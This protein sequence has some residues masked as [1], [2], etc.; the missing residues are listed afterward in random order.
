MFETIRILV[1]QYMVWLIFIPF[2][3]AAVNNKN[4][5]AEL[6]SVFYYL[7]IAV[8]TQIISYV[9]WLN[10]KPNL[11][12]LHVYTILEFLILLRFYSIILRGFVPRL[13]FTILLILFPLFAFTD[14]IFL[15]NIFTV[16]TYSRSVEALIFI[17]LSVSWFVKMVSED[18]NFHSST[19]GISYINFGFFIYFSGS[20]VL[21][22]FQSYVA[23]FSKFLYLN[24]WTIHSLLL[25]ILYLLITIGLWKFKTK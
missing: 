13:L 3:I 20:L 2:I 12:L 7:I 21:F 19:P 4:Y 24:I 14:S 25:I 5:P 1:F 9:Y 10:S 11:Y 15:E 16:N 18:E 6:K 8:L 22:S 17:F 23:K